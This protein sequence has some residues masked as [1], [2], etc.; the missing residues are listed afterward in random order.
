MAAADSEVGGQAIQDRNAS[1]TS[2]TSAD[3]QRLPQEV[4]KQTLD[5]WKDSAAE[6]VRADLF[7]KKQ[8]VTDEELVMG[9]S[10]QKLV[11]TYINICGGERARV[12][13]E[14]KGG[15]ESVRNTFRRKRQAAQNAMKLAFRGK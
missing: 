3:M 8:F 5:D 9:G 12:F 13:W 1:T 7:D 6:Y 14:E 2:T 15:K 4:C 10:I 11:C